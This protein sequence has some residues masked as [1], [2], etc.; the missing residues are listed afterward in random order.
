[1]S[2]SSTSVI[3]LTTPSR[4]RIRAYAQASNDLN[5]LHLDA[6]IAQAAGFKD[7]IAHGMLIMGLAISALKQATNANI[8]QTS[9]VQFKA[10]VLVDTPLF[11]TYQK[12]DDRV[13]FNVVDDHDEIKISGT[14]SLQQ[15]ANPH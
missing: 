10:P 7:V 3:E 11:I 4:D 8:L 15:P 13:E 5:P 12:H 9:H 1:M 2:T 14:A 6:K